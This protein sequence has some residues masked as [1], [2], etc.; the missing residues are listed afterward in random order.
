ME[1][2]IKDLAGCRIIFYTNSD[3]NL[4]NQTGL[5]RENFDILDSILHYPGRE[6]RDANELYMANHYL[7]KLRLER[8][9][10][11]EYT[12]LADM[13][14]EVQVQT[15]LNHAWAEMAHDTIYKSPQLGG[16]G[17]NALEAVNRRLDKV[18][19]KYLLPAGYEFDKIVRE[20]Q[21][22]KEG[23]ELFDEGALEAIVGSENNNIRADALESFTDN[24]L[25][26]YDDVR[27]EYRLIVERL[28]EAARIARATPDV[29]I[30]TP[31]GSYPAKTAVDVVAGI[32]VILETYRY[33]EVNVT[34]DALCELF[35]GAENEAE[36]K[37]LLQAAERLSKHE[38]VV[39]QEHGPAVQSTLVDRIEGL[40]SDAK[41]PH[42]PLLTTIL[43]AI[44]KPEVTGTT[45]SS[46]TVTFRRGAVLASDT[47][48][49]IRGKAMQELKELVPL[50][51]TDTERRVILGALDEATRTPNMG[52]YSSEL[53]R[54]VVDNNRE[55]LEY[56]AEIVP[57]LSYEIL[58]S[59]EERAHRTY[60]NYR[61]LPGSMASDVALVEARDL[62]LKAVFDFR[63]AI[64]ADRRFV[65][66]KTLVGFES[67][68]PPAWEDQEF[69]RRETETYRREQVEILL[70]EV[71]DD[72]EDFWFDLISRCAQTQ[73]DDAAT[74]PIFGHFL[75]RLGEVKPEFV[76]RCIGRME[77]SL[78]R[79]IPSLLA[80]LMKGGGADEASRQIER[81]LEKGRYL[82][83]IAR[84]LRFAE[85]FEEGLLRRVLDRA[86]EQG[87]AP[88]VRDVM[89]AAEE[90]FGNNPG[91]LIDNVLVPALRYMDPVRDLSWVRV[92]WFSWMDS[93][94]LHALGEDQAGAVLDALVPYPDIERDAEHIVAVIAAHWPARVIDFLGRRQSYAEEEAPA[95][96]YRALPYGVH[97]LRDPLAANVEMLVRAGRRWYEARKQYFRYDGGQFLAVVFPDLPDAFRALLT[98]YIAG[99]D[100]DDVGYVLAILP[101]YDG[102]DIVYS[103]VKDV[104][105]QVEA[106][107][108][109]IGDVELV[110]DATDVASG[111]FGFVE[112]YTERKAAIELWLEDPRERVRAF[113]EPYIRDL[114]R[115]IARELKSAEASIASRKLDHGEDLDDQTDE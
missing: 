15:I 99:G 75:A 27:S 82:R 32:A 14:C 108:P 66:Y 19:R 13:R 18:A 20:F 83:E 34:F 49:A 95:D 87:D 22:L 71:D 61:E 111:E 69:G 3:V 37:P 16:F 55:I 112:L 38:I 107:D 43:G 33:A 26:Y 79:F 65:I 58:Q 113:A 53:A 97:D 1:S 36:R 103:L 63:D 7:V 35:A 72:S 25:P 46:S 23:K 84:Y 74:F 21:R 30:D 59:R 94:I 101:A 67:V 52:D 5:M 91:S 106:D 92:G 86:I 93:A 68:F 100:R 110:L 2:E 77:P 56:E 109:L 28:M 4:F 54:L 29:P 88:A 8:L 114:E 85:T 104:I 6:N 41:G 78:A 70:G 81:W 40:P 10:L 51:Q 115:S 98:D 57:S 73:S 12:H 102:R 76:L 62:L 48:R 47:L 105:A 50:A 60:E 64:N 31:F 45:S 96:R 24:V 42:L 89:L 39:W 11:P 80:G 44:L 90:Q 17:T 9:A